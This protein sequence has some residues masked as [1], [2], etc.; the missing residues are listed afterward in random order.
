[1]TLQE[2]A[3]TLRRSVRDGALLLDGSLDGLDGLA[4]LLSLLESTGL[5][6]ELDGAGVTAEGGAVRAAGRTTFLGAPADAQLVF[7]EGEDKKVRCA[8]DV[9]LASLSLQTLSQSA[10]VPRGAL[11]AAA[12]PA[13]TF[14]DV[15]LSARSQS[16]ALSVEV[17]DSA[18][19]WTLS[20][21]LNLSLKNIGFSLTRTLP[22]AN[23]GGAQ[24]DAQK[25][26]EFSVNGDM[27]LG[28][29]PLG[30][31]V[32]FPTAPLGLPDQW[33]VTLHS[34]QSFAAGL[35]DLVGL[36]GGSG[37]LDLPPGVSELASFSLE[38]FSATFSPSARSVSSVA[39]TLKSTE[40]WEMA[41][42]VNVEEVGLSLFVAQPANSKRTVSAEVYGKIGLGPQSKLAVKLVRPAGGGDWL[43]SLTEPLSLS[44]LAELA[45]VPGGLDVSSLQMPEELSN[46]TLWLNRFD[47]D[48]NPSRRS[49]SRIA[50]GL[51][52][53][54]QW[55]VIS[56]LSIGDPSVNLE[57]V[58]PFGG[59]Q[60]RAVKGGMGGVLTLGGASIYVGAQKADLTSGWQLTGRL[61]PGE[62]VR[63]TEIARDVL[64]G[65]ALPDEVPDLELSDLAL[66][67]TPS[68]GALAFRGRAKA[69]WDLPFGVEGLAVTTLDLD[70]QKGPSTGSGA[71]RVAGPVTCSLKLA[72]DAAVTVVE[73]LTF[74]RVALGYDLAA[75]GAWT[76]SGSVAA[77]I[78]DADYTLSAAL[79]QTAAQ[80]RISL[81]A[82]TTAATL[83]SFDGVGSLS[84][85]AVSIVVA[86]QLQ[87][88]QPPAAPAA[89][90]GAVSLGAS[91]PYTW[92]VVVTGGLKVT[93]VL[94]LEGALQLFK[95][96]DRAGLAFRATNA[97]AR[98]PLP[99][100]QHSAE[101]R[102]GLERISV[103][104]SSTASGAQTWAFD[105]AASVWFTG[106][107][108]K[109]QSLLAQRSTGTLKVDGAGLQ[110]SVNRLLRPLEIEAPDVSAGSITIELGTMALDASNLAL[111][112]RNGSVS[113]SLDF[114]VGLPAKL[115]N[116]FGK[117]SD[118]SPASR[119]F[120]TYDRANPA[121]VTK[122]R[123]GVDTALGVNIQMVTSPF[124][125]VRLTNVGQAA[126][127]DV[128][129]GDFGRIR[130]MAPVFSY[131]GDGFVARGGF[132]QVEP[133]MIPL[134]PLK[135]LLSGAGLGAAASAL[136]RGIPLQDLDIYDSATGRFKFDEFIRTIETLGGF[137]LPQETKDALRAIES[138]LDLL[139]DRFKSYLDVEIPQ[140]FQFDIS[141]TP[142][143]G[144]RGKV[145]VTGD[146]P[147]KFIYPSLGLVGP[148]LNGV[149]LYSITFGEVLGGSLMILD[150]DARFDSYDLLVLVA[151]MALPL[152]KLPILPDTRQLTR[153]LVVKRLFMVIIYQAGIPIPVPLFFDELGIEYLYLEGLELQTHWGFPRPTLSA[154]DA[155]RIFKDF[156]NFFTQRDHLLDASN[157]PA[158]LDLRLVVGPNYIQLPKYLGGKSLGS[159][160]E[161]TVVS[162]YSNL[163]H[164][165]NALKTLSLNELIQA[166]P[167]EKRVGS[168]QV[169][170]ASM[171]LVANWLITTPKEF[172]D[173]AFRR[174]NLPESEMGQTLQVL[175]PRPGKD[176]QGLV[177]FLR[178]EWAIAGA[179]SLSTTF[180]LVGASRGFGTGLR[181][182]GS[183]TDILEVEMGGAVV[184]D[185]KAADVFSLS[186]QTRLRVMGDEV[187]AGDLLITE[188]RLAIRGRLDLFPRSPVIRITGEVAG[189]VSDSEF[190]LGGSATVTAGGF[191]TLVSASAEITH[192]GV[193]VSGTWLNQTVTFSAQR[194][195]ASLE[196]RATLSPVTVGGAFSLTDA[197]G[198][199]GPLAVLGLDTSGAASVY[200]SARISLL[201]VTAG[202]SVSFSERGFELTVEGHVYNL[203]QA[204]LTARGA[205]LLNGD[206]FYVKATLRNDLF[207]YLKDNASR[208]INDA[209]SSATRRLS[210]AQ[211]QVDK[212]QRD[213]DTLNR[214]IDDARRTV[215]QEREGDQQRLRDAQ[216][217]VDRAQREVDTLNQQIADAR[218]T[219]EA[220]RVRDQQNL[221]NAQAAVQSAQNQVNSLQ[222]Q[223]DDANAKIKSLKHD[224]DKKKKWYKDLPWYKQSYGWTE[225]GAYTTAKGAEITAQ[226]T[227]IGGLE[228]AKATASGALELAKQS[229][230]GFEQ[231]SK[232]FPVDADPR[233]AG[234]IVALNAATGAL[235]TAKATLDGIRSGIKLVP[236]DADPRVS[237]L[238]VAREAATGALKVANGT[239]EGL[240]VSIGAMARVGDYIVK[241]GLGALL[242]V[243]AATF[244]ASLSVAQGGR[245]ALAADLVFMGSPRSVQFGFDFNDPLRGAQDLAQILMPK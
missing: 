14:G 98:I 216:A 79:E 12:V 184:I 158:G 196:L 223:I 76:L 164:L 53:E 168:E 95:Q 29:A 82:T 234:P 9:K 146:K 176:E 25:R 215:Q 211:A 225:L 50:F 220:E 239:L 16:R 201:G 99:I 54:A 230:R 109:I 212:A 10:L 205:N 41:P 198:A 144:A 166:L 177:V 136:P 179:A 49:I 138:R 165:L 236:V 218:R 217:Q 94:D 92:E 199:G 21:E 104:R 93:G 232:T 180:G 44:G 242:D 59:A 119:V 173:G 7:D 170:F 45:N 34:G 35:N 151:A 42:S 150:V 106:L 181:V 154:S 110:L 235:N 70:I 103:I 227:A 36:V 187:L 69:T 204:T 84:A 85:R 132:E 48:F 32:E 141:V 244:E 90:E 58:N 118:G 67:V 56:Q 107:P 26:V 114:G 194:Q 113:L 4:T 43:L 233:V 124:L 139:P 161:K 221:R 64:G 15:T 28:S 57:I 1:M 87:P 63:L 213:V 169:S 2:T 192:T 47:L 134:A 193:R 89:T 13:V 228:T 188:N 83:V 66:T 30:V 105:A 97:E 38:R 135:A 133:L 147:L 102:F 128:D 68:T 27:Q 81:T 186:G 17:K 229:L 156:E 20:D 143:G 61:Q 153:R 214:Q 189:R 162:A 200:I 23:G 6:L 231:A 91:S 112:F 197:S 8:L 203:F 115:N 155:A 11:D 108:E 100:P 22:K 130:L 123:I 167:L 183:I 5:R 46:A 148:V 191:F 71:Q 182:A 237:G 19:D 74:K 73:G 86:K 152:D 206:G 210:D 111:A 77:T 117:K 145:W 131:T 18:F 174:L 245:V 238:I 171:T 202:G 241:N 142:D 31:A 195:G 51:S 62:A 219:V 243:R 72:G 122:F 160:D 159:R 24:K 101:L 80:R 240:K 224:I 55:N 52:S 125:A 127:W 129:L 208:A 190:Y 175:P 39:L 121:S 207:A 178:G 163:A 78:F 226:Y 120:N 126:W 116:L 75:G 140:S 209:A 65:A 60:Q 3:E 222:R 149:E 172:R 96:A 88:S 137:P 37:G 33:G 40:T 157:P 185:T